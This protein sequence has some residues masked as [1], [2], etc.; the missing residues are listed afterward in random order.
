LNPITVN[1]TVGYG[2][3][4]G[5]SLFQGA[6]GESETE[7][8]QYSYSA[9]R[10]ALIA[11]GG[12]GASTVPAAD[13]TN[14]GNYWVATAE[15]KAL[16][17][18]GPSSAG[19]GFG[20]FASQGVNWTYNTTNGGSVASGTYDFFGVAAH[21]LTEVMG[22]ALFVGTDGIGSNSYTPLDLFH[23]SSDGVRE[24]PGTPPGYFFIDGGKTKLHNFKNNPNADLGDWANNP[25]KH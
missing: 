11:N 25:G 12:A 24:F 9:I 15:A 19:D 4:E 13:P 2:K 8:D 22:R 18:S 10:N 5:Q 17:W 20:G 1:I 14:G 3:I 16:G 21:E 23:Y 6:L 7:F